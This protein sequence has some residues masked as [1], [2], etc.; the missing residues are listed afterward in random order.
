MEI[1][2]L[3]NS[4]LILLIASLGVF[5][6]RCGS[7]ESEGQAPDYVIE[8]EKFIEMMTDFALVESTLNTNVNNQS[9]AAFDSAYNFN[10]LNEHKVSKGKYDSTVKYYSSEPEEFK[11]IM[12]TVLERLNIE[13]AKERS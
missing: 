6:T 3:K 7:G 1:M 11:R 12:E 9:G 2:N 4:L 10:I 8:E 13:K 5:M